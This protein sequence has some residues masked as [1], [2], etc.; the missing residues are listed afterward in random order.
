VLEHNAGGF[1]YFPVND[2]TSTDIA[3]GRWAREIVP[4]VRAAIHQAQFTQSVQ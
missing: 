2:G 4:A 3:L 1:V